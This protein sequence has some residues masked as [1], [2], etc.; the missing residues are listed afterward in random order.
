M[1]LGEFG[2]A[3]MRAAG[4]RGSGSS[5][6]LKMSRAWPVPSCRTP[7]NILALPGQFTIPS[8]HIY[9]TK[10]TLHHSPSSV[11]IPIRIMETG[12]GER[13]RGDVMV[14]IAFC[15]YLLAVIVTRIPIE[16]GANFVQRVAAT[17]SKFHVSIFLSFLRR[18]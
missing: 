10:F 2:E 13:F 6:R 14:G 18:A 12:N 7:T 11:D 4:G 8:A 16:S 3:G 5:N 17:H 1:K 15:H 9:H